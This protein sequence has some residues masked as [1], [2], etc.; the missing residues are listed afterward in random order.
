MLASITRHT[1][2]CARRPKGR[3]R[4]RLQ[5]VYELL[6]FFAGSPGC[7]LILSSRGR[8]HLVAVKLLH[9]FQIYQQQRR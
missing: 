7:M 3:P 5:G 9:F 1:L 6:A 4:E 2:D 8:T